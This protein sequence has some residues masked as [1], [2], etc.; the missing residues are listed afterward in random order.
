VAAKAAVYAHTVSL[1]ER[2]RQLQGAEQASGSR[3]GNGD[4]AQLAE[5]LLPSAMA[6]STSSRQFLED[7]GQGQLSVTRELDGLA[8]RVYDPPQYDLSGPPTAIPFEQ[9]LQG[10]SLQALVPR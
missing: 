5:D 2:E 9:L 10:D 6:D 4:E 3:N 1:R 8:D 7:L